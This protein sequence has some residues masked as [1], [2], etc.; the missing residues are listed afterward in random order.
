MNC[1]VFSI[2][3][4]GSEAWALS[5]VPE[6]K[7]EAFE[8]WCLRRIGKIISNWKDKLTNGRV[9]DKQKVG[10]ISYLTH[11][12]ENAATTAISCGCGEEITF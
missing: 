11:R 6:N 8:M 1:Y 7:T 4:Y 5:K 2:F 3:T 9:L 12:K 10:R